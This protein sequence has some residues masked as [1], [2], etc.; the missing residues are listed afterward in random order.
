VNM[1]MVRAQFK[2]PRDDFHFPPFLFFPSFLFGGGS[3]LGWD[4][5][6]DGGEGGSRGRGD[7][8]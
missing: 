4:E 1:C 5:L 2:E 7:E 8:G 6:L 3:V